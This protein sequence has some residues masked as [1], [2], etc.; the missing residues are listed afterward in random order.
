MKFKK[1]DHIIHNKIP[2][3]FGTITD[4]NQMYYMVRWDH[5]E[6]SNPQTH[7]HIE[8]SY[9]LDIKKHRDKM[10]KKLLGSKDLHTHTQIKMILKDA[11]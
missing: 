2:S 10:L 8:N 6:F 7:S 4:I 3:L 9:H 5:E 1:G 11:L